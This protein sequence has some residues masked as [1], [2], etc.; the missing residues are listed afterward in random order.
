M[1][2][3]KDDSPKPTQNNDSFNRKE[4]LTAMA[5]EVIIPSL[6]TFSNDLNKLESTWNGYKQTPNIATFVALKGFYKKALLSYQDIEFLNIG[7]AEDIDF[8]YYMNTYPIDAN[9][10]EE[11]IQTGNYKFEVISTRSVQG[12]QALDYLYFGRPGADNLP[13]LD[14]STI[15]YIDAVIARLKALTSEVSQEWNGAYRTT[16]INNDGS[17]VNASVDQIVNDLVFYYEKFLRA[18]KV[19]IPAGVYSSETLP[20]KVESYYIKDF[21]KELLIKAVTNFKSIFN[22]PKTY[23]SYLDSLGTKKDGVL[24]SKAINDQLDVALQTI[25]KLDSELSTQVKT[26]NTKMTEA[27]DA[28]QKVVVMLKVD[29][30]QAMNITIDYIDA[31]GD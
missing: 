22:E 7:K 21:N 3:G 10:I 19:G 8:P 25:Q 26:D 11:N 23:A 28:L 24:L 6:T 27:F 4:L 17:S 31:D 2:C 1:S 12:L 15:K 18:G 9:K 29:M 5:D 20:N 30:T 13:K 16:F 14:D